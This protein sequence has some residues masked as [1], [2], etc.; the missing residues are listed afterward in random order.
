[1][2]LGIKAASMRIFYTVNRK[3]PNMELLTNTTSEWL[4]CALTELGIGGKTTSGYGK[5][6]T[7]RD[8][9][10]GVLTDLLKEKR[11]KIEQEREK[12]RKQR[13]Q[14]K[15]EAYL[16]TLTE[17][18][19][20]A[21][22]IDNLGNAQAEIEASKSDIY[23]EVLALPAEEGK[24]AA[25]ALRRYWQNTGDW[26]KPSRKQREKNRVIAELIN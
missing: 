17:G 10:D 15:L 19:R 25:Q 14:K 23:N 9:T 24:I 22:K 8:V 3:A 13:K 26:R 11:K 18:E 6:E 1:D 2:F 4:K 5:F 21:Y 12:L 20:V 7:V 16:A